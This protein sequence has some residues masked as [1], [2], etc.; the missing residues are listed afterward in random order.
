[1]MLH[2]ESSWQAAETYGWDRRKQ[3]C[4]VLVIKQSYHFDGMGEVTP[5]P[6]S[7]PVAMA[8]EFCGDPQRSSLIAAAETMSFKA[9][10]ELYG[11]LTAHPTEGCNTQLMDVALMLS[12][13]QHTPFFSKTLRINGRRYWRPAVSVPGVGSLFGLVASVPDNIAPLPVSYEQTY[14]GQ[15]P[16]DEENLYPCNPAG[17]GYRLKRRQAREVELAAIEEVGSPVKYPG[18]A[19]KVAGFGPLPAFWSPRFERQPAIR[20]EA[21]L[22]GDY[23]FATEVDPQAYNVAP[24]DQ[25]L[26]L[27]FGPGLRLA[28]WGVSVRQ[29]PNHPIEIDLPYQ[30]P[31]ITFGQSNGLRRLDGVCD[32]LVIDSERQAF[33]LVWR[34][35]HPV[36]NLKESVLWNI[37][38]RQ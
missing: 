29:K 10:F 4:C 3:R 38:S 6:Q 24:D 31:Q 8:D 27:R 28:L 11:Q 30:P 18:H 9:G 12:E 22:T 19:V 23:P 33:H 1:M 17:R 13:G 20:Q 14:G 35:T 15:D 26:D 5:W 37:V 16:N 2:N 25:Q 34:V 7:A 21:I 36:D 32:T